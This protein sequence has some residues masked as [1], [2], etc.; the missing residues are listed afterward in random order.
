MKKEESKTKRVTA[1]LNNKEDRETVGKIA[2]DLMQKTP[3]DVPVVDLG[4]DMLQDYMENLWLCVD[5]GKK[6]LGTD[7]FVVV[8]QKKERL[9]Q[10][11]VRNQFLYRLS[12]PTP[13]YNQSVFR[14][15]FEDDQLEYFWSLPDKES[16]FMLRNNA[17]MVSPEEHQMLQFVLE[18]FDGT[19]DN[20]AQ[21]SNG[22]EKKDPL[23]V[24]F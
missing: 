1:G 22:E 6:G 23:S 10:N 9:L 21:T 11:V 5:R 13:T 17:L 20:L 3:E 19:L 2:T 16:C 7:F 8:L 24:I 14:Y 15:L 12:C 4:K 18:F